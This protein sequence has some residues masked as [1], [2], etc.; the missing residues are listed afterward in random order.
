MIDGLLKF[1]RGMMQID[2]NASHWGLPEINGVFGD[3]GYLDKKIDG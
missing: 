2:E 1:L 3:L